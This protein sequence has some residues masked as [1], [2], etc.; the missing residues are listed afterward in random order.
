[1]HLHF[2]R[3]GF[4]IRVLF[5]RELE[6]QE[7][8]KDFST[9]LG[10]KYCVIGSPLLSPLSSR[11]FLIHVLFCV[12]SHGKVK[13]LSQFVP[14]S[15]TSDLDCSLGIQFRMTSVLSGKIYIICCQR[16]SN[17]WLTSYTPFQ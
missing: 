2:F 6:R 14:R 1:M 8:Q 13:Y 11:Q 5:L 17:K 16:L 4:Q 15:L 10:C 7:V 3:E 12:L 9:I